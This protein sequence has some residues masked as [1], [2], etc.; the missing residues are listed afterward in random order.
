[1]SETNS[2]KCAIC[3]TSLLNVFDGE[4]NRWICRTCE[5][6]YFTI[7]SQEPFKFYSISKPKC[8]CMCHDWYKEGLHCS[9]C[10]ATHQAAPI[11]TPPTIKPKLS[12]FKHQEEGR[13]TLKL[14][15][16]ASD[17]IKEGVF[18]A[19]QYINNNTEGVTR[20]EFAANGLYYVVA[21]LKERRNVT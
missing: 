20:I 12:L 19:A 6:K 15:L 16:K 17:S 18:Q 2:L 7:T 5:P 8:P 10:R 1:M 11:L 14:S 4:T 13:K 9:V 21:K 3:G